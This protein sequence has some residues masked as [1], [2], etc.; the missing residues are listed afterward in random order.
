MKPWVEGEM[1]YEFELRPS[2]DVDSFKIPTE[3]KAV[4]LWN[5]IGGYA[6][7]SIEHYKKST[8]EER[9]DTLYILT[10]QRSLVTEVVLK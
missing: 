2:K 5:G 7:E 10:I 1:S 8:D 4:Y 6:P 3:L 9:P